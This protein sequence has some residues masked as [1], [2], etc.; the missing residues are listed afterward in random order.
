M[1]MGIN[2]FTQL[3]IEF[4]RVTSP[5]SHPINARTQARGTVEDKNHAWRQAEKRAACRSISFLLTLR[6]LNCSAC[7]CSAL[8]TMAQI[9]NVTRRYLDRVELACTP[10]FLV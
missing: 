4:T 7:L 9:H 3:S 8:R 6:C 1:H 2:R 5:E 10:V